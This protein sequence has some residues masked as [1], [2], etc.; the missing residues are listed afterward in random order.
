M[1][2]VSIHVTSTSVQSQEHLEWL[3][4]LGRLQGVGWGLQG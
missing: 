4:N 2:N 1:S 3:V